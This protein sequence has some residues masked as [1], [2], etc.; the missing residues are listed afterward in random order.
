MMHVTEA[1]ME[2]ADAGLL[3]EA[4]RREA[5]AAGAASARGARQSDEEHDRLPE[6]VR[7]EA[8]AAGAASA[9]GPRSARGA[10]PVEC[11]GIALSSLD[12]PGAEGPAC[13]HST[14]TGCGPSGADAAAERQEEREEALGDLPRRERA[15]S[16]RR[17]NTEALEYVQRTARSG[18]TSN[19]GESDAVGSRD[20]LCV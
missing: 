18:G 7:R 6:A 17:N 5:I 9:R 12:G 2:T 1:G 8:L 15:P 11:C 13:S 14:S 10:Q 4:M 16:V 3:P 19:R 20:D